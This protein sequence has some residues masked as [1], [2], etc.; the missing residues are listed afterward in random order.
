MK[1][2]SMIGLFLLLTLWG[3][4]ALGLWLRTPD[5]FSQSE[6]RKLAQKP[7]LS[8]KELLSGRYMS[9]VQSYSED[10]FPFR[11]DFRMVKA[12]FSQKVLGQKDNNS[13]Y[14]AEN[15]LVKLDYP[16]NASAVQ[17]NA[18]KL[19]A[20]CSRYYPD[21][22]PVFCLVPDKGYYLA[23]RNGYPAMDYEVMEKLVSEALDAQTVSLFDVLSADSYY[24]TD[25][26]WRQEK[27]LPAAAAIAEALGIPVPESQNYVQTVLT[28]AFYGV[29]AGQAALPV[30]PDSLT[31]LENE[32]LSAC[33]VTVSGK[34]SAVYNL[35][36][37][38]GRDDYEVFLSGSAGVLEITNPAGD[39]EKTL[40][41]FRD[42]F[43]SSMLPLLVQGYGRIVA[44]DIRYYPSQALETVLPEGDPDVLLLYSS[45]VLNTPGIFK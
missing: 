16:M 42:S 29:Y 19:A 41:I 34:S 25:L 20:V 24:A 9:G 43:G 11:E 39:P 14:P 30:H 31:V 23:Q 3:G 10:Q 13:L 35:S 40:V 44:L 18:K 2:K 21:S 37:L 15:Q 28:D 32:M 6:R 8:G 17:S 5:A 7:E 4:L 36:Y 38:G 33:T 27:L 45:T 12:V 26:H 22:K 1:K